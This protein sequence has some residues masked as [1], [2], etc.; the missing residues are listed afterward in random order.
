MVNMLL[1]IKIVFV[2]CIGYRYDKV[3]A[4]HSFLMPDG[5]NVFF[6]SMG[7]KSYYT[8]QCFFCDSKTK[9]FASIKF[10]ELS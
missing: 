5:Y 7:D 8:N 6:Y 2:L 1:N 3:W 9:L 4:V 10:E